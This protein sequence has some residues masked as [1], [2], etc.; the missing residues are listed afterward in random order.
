[1]EQPVIGGDVTGAWTVDRI[2]D[3]P[4]IAG[5]TVSLEFRD[6]RLTGSGSCNRFN[7][8]YT[9]EDGRL[10]IGM[11]AAT[12]KACEATLM[13]QEQRFFQALSRVSAQRVR[14]GTRLELLADDRTT[15]VISAHR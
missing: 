14:D 4:V 5:T 15:V 1:M 6:G 7:A 11:A 3:T 2:V 13:E 12:R 8:S 9:D 10:T